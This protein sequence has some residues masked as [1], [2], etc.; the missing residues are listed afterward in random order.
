VVTVEREALSLVS[1]SGTDARPA[2]V[3]TRYTLRPLDRSRFAVYH[4]GTGPALLTAFT[5]FTGNRP[6]YF[7]DGPYT[8]F[9]GRRVSPG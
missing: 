8:P 2:P 4:D 3:R 6:D 7:F 1:E 5:G 9:L